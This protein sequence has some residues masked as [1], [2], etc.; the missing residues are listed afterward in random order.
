[1]V[2]LTMSDNP[3]LDADRYFSALEREEEA[4]T[5][6]ECFYC[7]KPILGE[8][9]SYYGDEFIECEDG[10]IHY[11]ECWDQYGREKKITMRAE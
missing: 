8:T 11:D 6:G 10:M 1:M 3:A 9:D 7:G 5:I 4:R 2:L